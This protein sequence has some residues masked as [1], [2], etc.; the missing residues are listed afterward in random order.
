VAGRISAIRK[1]RLKWPNPDRAGLAWMRAKLT[2][3]VT[4]IPMPASSMAPSPTNEPPPVPAAMIAYETM[5]WKEQL[6][7]A[8]Q[9]SHRGYRPGVAALR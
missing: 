1:E 9:V 2:M 8:G 7:D 4:G 6:A 5:A 3:A